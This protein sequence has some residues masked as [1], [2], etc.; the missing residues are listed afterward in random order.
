MQYFTTQDWKAVIKVI[1]IANSRLEPVAMRQNVLNA[2]QKLFNIER[3][4]FY[5]SSHDWRNLDLNTVV[6]L[7]IDKR[8]NDQYAQNYYQFSPALRPENFRK[9]VFSVDRVI[10]D[11]DWVRS[12]FYDALFRP[13]NIHYELV[14]HPFRGARSMGLLALFRSKKAGG[15]NERDMLVARRLVHPLA[16]TLDNVQ[17]VSRIK[18]DLDQSRAAI[19]SFQLGLVL[20]DNE[21]R[22]VYW[23]PKAKQIFLSLAHKL[24]GGDK[25]RSGVLPVPSDIEQDCLA[26]KQLFENKS[27][28]LPLSRV[29]TIDIEGDRRF[30][31]MIYLTQQPCPSISNPCFVVSIE[32][33]LQTG[34]IRKDTSR[35]K[36]HLTSREAEI[37]S[38][39]SQ[40][41]TN[42]EIAKSLSISRLTVETHM[43]NI[44]EK[45]GVRN[46]VGLSSQLRLS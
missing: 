38:L 29:R 33:T 25:N 18:T 11:S 22:P 27:Q 32:D 17:L 37:A 9:S 46:R 10:S 40:G 6:S 3:G 44:F 12:E 43:K 42:G 35:I 4:N 26:L 20:L 21:V 19:E 14:I 36:Y 30:E 8:Y 45:V 1:E 39:V 23:N 7:D 24:N 5:L 2:M 15:F 28:I 34:K 13:Q 31:V 41:L 16:I